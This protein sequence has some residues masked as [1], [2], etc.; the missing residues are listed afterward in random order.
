MNIFF[1]NSLQCR[2][3]IVLLFDDSFSLNVDVAF[4]FMVSFTCGGT[5]YCSFDFFFFFYDFLFSS[6]PFRSSL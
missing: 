2:G 5:R 1:P 3:K 4:G 6:L